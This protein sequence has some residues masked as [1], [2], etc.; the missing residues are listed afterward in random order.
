MNIRTTLIIPTY[1]WPKALE[2]VLLSYK[3]QTKYT[4]EVIIADDGSTD[5]TRELVERFQSDFPTKLR[6]IWHEDEGFRKGVIINKAI[7]QAEGDYIIQIDGDCIMHKHFIEDHILA[8]EKDTYLFGSRV[9]LK[10]YSIDKIFK[11][12]QIDFSIFSNALIKR[13]RS[14]YIPILG[15]R[16]KRES[17]MSK[18]VRGCNLSY[19]KA[20]YIA[21]NGYNEDLFGWG[22]ED[23]ELV[24]RMVNNGVFGKRLKFRGIVFHIWHNEFS[25]DR[26]SNNHEIQAETIAQKKVWCNN[27]IDKYLSAKN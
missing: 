7:A 18:K 23:T 13:G 9:S 15:K 2:L 19:W 16:Y 27:G 5:E 25:K 1:N 17:P 21:V 20:D 3:R 24:V 26:L 4:N 12:K 6:Y 22:R 8:I 14:L 11:H 10:Q